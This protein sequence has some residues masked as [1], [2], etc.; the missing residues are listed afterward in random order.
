MK[1]NEM[2]IQGFGSPQKIILVTRQS[3]SHGILSLP[4][5]HL[6]AKFTMECINHS[7]TVTCKISIY[8]VCS[9]INGT[10]YTVCPGES[11]AHLMTTPSLVN[12]YILIAAYFALDHRHSPLA[13]PM[14][15]PCIP[16]HTVHL[17]SLPHPISNSR[18]QPYGP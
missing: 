6:T 9:V 1:P 13:F 11:W 5:V 15:G 2:G 4:Y 16:H 14:G 3:F 10:S 7:C 8:C 17:L 18:H 12:L